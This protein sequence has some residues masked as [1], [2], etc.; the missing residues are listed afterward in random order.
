MANGHTRPQLN[1]HSLSLRLFRKVT[2][3]DGQLEFFEIRGHYEPRNGHQSPP[4]FPD[5][6]CFDWS[7]NR[8][9]V[10]VF[11]DDSW[12]QYPDLISLLDDLPRPCRLI[13][14]STFESFDLQRRAETIARYENEPD[15]ELLTI[16]ARGNMRR[17]DKAGFD[18][19]T[20]QSVEI[21][22][23]DAKAMR[24]AVIAG[25]HLKKPALPDPLWV[26]KR[27]NA[28]DDIM[29]LRR[30]RDARKKK[31]GRGFLFDS[32]KDKYAKDLV[33]K[34]PAFGL[35]PDVRRVALGPAAYNLTIVAAVGKCAEHAVSR[36]EFDRL[37][38][39]YGHAYPSQFRSDLMYHGWT[40]KK[41]E[42]ISLSEY[43]RELRWLYHQLKEAA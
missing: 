39:L 15:V 41:K 16:P 13:G 4:G 9:V 26:K 19:K 14:E 11:S 33:S 25:M 36:R 17:R 29:R 2:V 37:A 6:V 18:K 7:M 24:Q 35:Q 31:K 5:L 28:C 12:E 43:R 30:G 34:L 1:G 42:A 3:L 27:E 40:E 20:S 32:H 10:V 8:G 21:D 23:E 22:V 38:G